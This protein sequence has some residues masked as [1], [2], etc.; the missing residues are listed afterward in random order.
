MRGKLKILNWR[1]KLKIK[2]K[3]TEESR[4]KNTKLKEWTLDFKK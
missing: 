1:I 4:K 2:I 3:F